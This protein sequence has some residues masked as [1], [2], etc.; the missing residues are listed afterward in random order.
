MIQASYQKYILNFKRP[1]GTSRGTYTT[2]ETYFIKLIKHNTTGIGECALFR[3]LSADDRP[4]FE[5]K[6]ASTVKLI[7][8]NGLNNNWREELQVWPSILFGMETALLS[9]EQ[10]SPIIYPS[11]F[12]NG[13]NGITT[14]GL[15]W[16]GGI[17]F[18]QQQI[19]EKLTKG[20]KCIK[21]KIGALNWID[22]HRI[23]QQL[24]AK[25]SPQTLEIRVDANGGFT[26]KNAPAIL[27]E[28]NKLNIHSIEQPI[29]AGQFSAMASLC[30]NSPIA[31]ALDEELIGRYTKTE[32]QSMLDQ[33]KPHYII[34]KPGILGGLK[35]AEAW[36][37]IAE[38]QHIGWWITSSLESNIGLSAIAQWTYSL[39]SAMPQGLGTGALFT[40]NIASPLDMVG[41]ELFYNPNK[42]WQTL[43]HEWI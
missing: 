21:L 8:E 15:I 17:D 39:Q 12:T 38:K 20:F 24:R 32:K 16:M 23:L 34:L 18:M 5:T 3:G 25:Y 10:N 31:I 40:N 35:E 11:D 42:N 37:D 13:Q 43:P 6:L 4:N 7:N 30:K 41:E 29:A 1:A 36:I 9:L 28:L 14:N 33:L 26:P 19:N 27:E 22:E 2:K